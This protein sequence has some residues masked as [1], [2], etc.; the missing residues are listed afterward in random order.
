MK[1]L[2]IYTPLVLSAVLLI[3]WLS[4]GDAPV[5]TAA[6]SSPSPAE[7]ADLTTPAA[8]PG[9]Q[10]PVP[11][12]LPA[13]LRDTEV[14][15]QLQVDAQGNLLITDQLRH[16]FD[17]FLA[18]VGEVSQEQA[19][20]KIRAYLRQNL[21]QPAQTQALD[22]LDDY[23]AYLHAVV[24]LESA[25][26]RAADLDALLAREDAVQRLRA[27]IFSA[28]AHAAFFAKE[29]LYHRFTLQRMQVMQDA[30]LDAV[31]RGERIEAL[32]DDLPDALRELLLPQLH[33]D[34]R[35]QSQA[36]LA[37]GGSSD[38]LRNL[39]MELVGPQATE[40]LEAL[41]SQRAD[42]QQRLDSF[43][44]EREQIMQHPGLAPTD[45]TAMLDEL[46]AR[47]FAEHEQLRVRALLDLP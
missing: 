44:S 26:P 5:E 3:G 40:R 30:T 9:L 31:E 45:Q 22:L 14:D 47:N 41:D 8:M 46:L 38:E 19:E 20:A 32:R 12:A 1:A 43:A 25:Y 24:D 15:G 33:A 6:V 23:L 34:L 17:Y 4:Q 11:E 21:A 2:I 27:S 18:T 35:Q 36:L 16:L 28:E 10:A 7:T 13:S 37:A 39:R 42:W 29:E